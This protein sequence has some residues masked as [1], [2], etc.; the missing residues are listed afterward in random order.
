MRKITQLLTALVFCSLIIFASCGKGGD[1][2]PKVDVRVE[3]GEFIATVVTGAPDMVKFDRTERDEW[4]DLNINFTF[5]STA[6]ADGQY[7]GT[8]TVSDVPTNPGAEYVWGTDGD[9]T[10]ANDAGTKITFDGKTADVVATDSS[11]TLKFTST[12]PAARTAEFAGA[13]EFT[14]NK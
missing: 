13:W 5:V 3:K 1:D 14:W 9:W 8:Y 10:F 2:D 4:G 11:V 6:N 12:E 7:G